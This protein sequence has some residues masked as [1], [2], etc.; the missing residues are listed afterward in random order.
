MRR[1]APAASTIT[2]DRNRT[3]DW[4]PRNERRAV[5][6]KQRHISSFPKQLVTHPLFGVVLFLIIFPGWALVSRLQSLCAEGDLVPCRHNNPQPVLTRQL[7][8]GPIGTFVPNWRPDG[9]CGNSFPAPS[10]HLISVCNPFVKQHCC[11]QWGWCGHGPEYCT[12]AVSPPYNISG[13]G[14]T[15]PFLLGIILLCTMIAYKAPCLCLSCS[16]SCTCQPALVV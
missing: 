4:A 14:K 6:S 8:T 7:T 12:Q 1:R 5:E 2:A 9:R 16:T 3:Q 13:T 11:S 10:G 15:L